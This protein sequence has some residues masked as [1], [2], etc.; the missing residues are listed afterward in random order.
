MSS[1]RYPSTSSSNS[2]YPRK[3]DYSHVNDNQQQRQSYNKYHKSNTHRNYQE[4]S[5][6]DRN[7]NNHSQRDNVQSQ[8]SENLNSKSYFESAFTQTTLI[9]IYY[10]RNTQNTRQF[11]ATDRLK[12]LCNKFDYELVQ[13]SQR[14]KGN[15]QNEIPDYRK[16]IHTKTFSKFSRCT[17]GHSN[18]AAK[19]NECSKHKTNTKKSSDKTHNSSSSSSSSESNSESS[20]SSETSSDDSSY[21]GSSDEIEGFDDIRSMEINRKRN[22]PQHLHQDITFNE[23]NQTNEGPMCKCK[24]KNTTFGTR[25]QIYYGEQ[26]ITKC[27]EL[28]SNSDRLY[29]YRMTITPFTNFIVSFF[30]KF[31]LILYGLLTYK[32]DKISNYNQ[33]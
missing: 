33:I 7:R 28:S 11:Y 17:C 27:N 21:D 2:G 13:R 32:I 31:H 24:L 12:D 29:H 23:P 4:R 22:H 1:S 30:R 6:H 3:R 5:H 10:E 8:T 9:P 16:L 18:S 14:L 25:H 20:T 26:K 15:Q 19:S